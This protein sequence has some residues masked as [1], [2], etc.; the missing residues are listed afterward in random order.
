MANVR[1]KIGETAQQIEALWTAGTLASL[2]DIQLLSRFME[3]RDATAESAFRELVHRHGPMVLGV[4]RQVLRQSH[5]VDDAFQATFLVLVRKAHAIRVHESLGPWLYSVA[6]RTALRARAIAARHRP[7]DAEQIEAAGSTQDDSYKVDLRPLLIEE[8][9]LLPGKYRDPIVLCH[10]EGK[11]H[12]EAARLLRWPVGT[13]SGRL[14]RGR[15]ILKG[16]LE[17]RGLTAS[18]AML[19][20]GWLSDS[21][22][23]LP[24]A[25]LDAAIAT[26]RPMAAAKSVSASVLSL[27]QGVLQAMFLHKLKSVALAVVL[28]GT[29]LGGVGVWAHWPSPS[30]RSGAGGPS[31]SPGAAASPGA[32][33]RAQP[34]AQPASSSQSSLAATGSQQCPVFGEDGPPPYCPL[35]LAA[36][37][38]ARVVD[39]FHD[40]PARAQ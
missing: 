33:P 7:T 2:S 31:D 6:H 23:A 18:S 37:A 22:S 9:S 25:L 12:E 14:S 28:T 5:D 10:L 38:L 8:L 19:A 30:S 32:T 1:L 17:R 15:R 11:T 21:A 29:L 36:N 34:S 16:R 39:H 3:E 40:G 13:L 35:T 20:A 27:T 26:A 4:C 24:S